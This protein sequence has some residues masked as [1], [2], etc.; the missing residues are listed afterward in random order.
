MKLTSIV[1]LTSILSLTNEQATEYHNSITK[2]TKF[3]AKVF[4]YK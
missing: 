4:G 1:I 2:L 3:A